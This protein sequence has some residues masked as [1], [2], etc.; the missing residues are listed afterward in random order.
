MPDTELI[1]TVP[2]GHIPPVELPPPNRQTVGAAKTA[3]GIRNTARRTT[4]K[5]FD[6]GGSS[7][8]RIYRFLIDQKWQ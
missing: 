8:M 1:I 3:A 5:N 7:H 6:M 4:M 2:E